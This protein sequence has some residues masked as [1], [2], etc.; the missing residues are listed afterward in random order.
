MVCERLVTA[1]R[2]GNQWQWLISINN[3]NYF[4]TFDTQ[5]TALSKPVVPKV[6]KRISCLQTP[7]W[8]SPVLCYPWHWGSRQRHST[9]KWMEAKQGQP[10]QDN[11]NMESQLEGT[12]VIKFRM[13]DIG[14]SALKIEERSELVEE[15]HQKMTAIISEGDVQGL[16]LY[17]QKWPKTVHLVLKNET[18]K[19]QLLVEGLNIFGNNVNLQDD[20]LSAIT[21]VMVY[22]VPI[23]MS[24][25]RLKDIF[26]KYGDVI[27]VDDE[28]H[29]VNGRMTS[30]DTGNKIVSMSSVKIHIP[31]HMTWPHR[32]QNVSIN[33]WYRGQDRFVA[34]NAA[35]RIEKC[36]KCGLTS[37]ATENCPEKRKVCYNCKQP[38]HMNADCPNSQKSGKVSVVENADVLCFLGENC[39]FSNLNTEYPVE[40]VGISYLCNEQYIQCAKASMFGDDESVIIVLV[41]LILVKLTWNTQWKITI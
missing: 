29:M 33:T 37:H 41:P 15:I 34:P 5:E 13:S 14:R 6:I 7:Q 3:L 22:D 9:G 30:W 35:T 38:G 36:I 16:Q 20:S 40:I 28:K 27:Q 10:R 18:V 17:P 2:R 4:I 1:H 23:D 8:G 12:F 32:D 31:P 19:N 39:V 26:S 24:N 21:K 25:E 11:S